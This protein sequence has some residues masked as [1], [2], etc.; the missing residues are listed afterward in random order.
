M[1]APGIRGGNGFNADLCAEGRG[2]PPPPREQ[3]EV[4][5]LRG[6]GGSAGEAGLSGPRA[7][8]GAA[9][10]PGTPREGGC[11]PAWGSPG[12]HERK[13]N[14][15]AG[16]EPRVRPGVWQRREGAESRDPGWVSPS[17]L[18][19]KVTAKLKRQKFPHFYSLRPLPALPG[20]QRDCLCEPPSGSSTKTCPPLHHFWSWS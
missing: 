17:I 8:P 14:S 15:A 16:E 19:A 7:R 12:D 10:G 9:A 13:I 4:R 5:G 20:T 1:V 6:C 18:V 11:C 2:T 3:R